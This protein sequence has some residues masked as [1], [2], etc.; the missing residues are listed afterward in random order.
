MLLNRIN[1]MDQEKKAPEEEIANS[2][3]GDEGKTVIVLLDQASLEIVKTKSG[4]FALLNCDDHVSL[5]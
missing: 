4:D 3:S 5:M 2:S 1:S